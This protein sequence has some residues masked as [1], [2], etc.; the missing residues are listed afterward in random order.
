MLLP[1]A[2]ALVAGPFAPSSLAG[3]VGTEI[4]APDVPSLALAVSHHAFADR[5][6]TDV[7]V[8]RTGD[9]DL[10][11]EAV[12]LAGSL[13]ARA[14]VL[15]G[16]TK[17]LAGEIARVT[18]GPSA[19]DPP[20]VW[21]LG[22]ADPAV[23]SGYDVRRL[24]GDAFA[25]ASA[26]LAEGPVAGTADRYVLYPFHDWAAAAVAAA[27]AASYALPL[28]PMR[29]ATLPAGVEPA[30]RT[31]IVIGQATVPAGKFAK[32]DRAQGDNPATLSADAVRFYRDEHPGGSP[33]VTLPSRPVAADGF[34]GEAAPALLAGIV[35]ALGQD[36]GATSPLLLTQGRPDA[37]AGASCQSLPAAADN[38]AE[39]VVLASE[40]TT[41]VGL[42][43]G[44]ASG[45]LPA[46]GGNGVEQAAAALLLTG[47]LVAFII[48]RRWA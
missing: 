28:I 8:T 23:G 43:T 15:I 45:T 12:A 11:A 39:C 1:L 2:A 5:S 41:Y 47:A 33:P 44:A 36:A 20:R 16:G 34:G 26:L 4:V 46:T 7:V 31:A 14:P 10:W 42:G 37:P 19:A 22:G 29:D 30:G 6:T 25:V 38:T 21:V 27:F 3:G 35:S 13:P 24:G 9:N 48:R 17:G 32:V 18:G 40:T